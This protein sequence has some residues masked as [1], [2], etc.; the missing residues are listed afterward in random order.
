MCLFSLKTIILGLFLLGSSFSIRLL[1]SLHS[2][3]WYGLIFFIVYIGGLLVLFIYISSLNFN[4][5]FYLSTKKRLINIL[6]KTKIVIILAF[7]LSQVIWKYSTKRWKK[8][9][10]AKYRLNL[11]KEK[12]IVF[13]ISIGILLLLV[14][15]V[16][17][18]LSFRRRGALRPLY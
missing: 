1:I 10:K 2:R 4:P 15:W 9:D 17:T 5:A 13:L 16:I 8:I 7:C 18:K 6:L 11:F 12:E 3:S 14:L